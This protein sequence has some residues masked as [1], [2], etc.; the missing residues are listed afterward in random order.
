MI[1]AMR[2]S[3]PTLLMLTF[4]PIVAA[5]DIAVEVTYCGCDE[6]TV[7]MPKAFSL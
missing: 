6:V 1:V 2:I 7:T 5:S 4:L 3:N